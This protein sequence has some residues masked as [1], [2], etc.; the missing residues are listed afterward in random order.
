[1]KEGGQPERGAR[2]KGG[3]GGGGGG[4]GERDLIVI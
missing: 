2:V 3:G 4:G 1:M